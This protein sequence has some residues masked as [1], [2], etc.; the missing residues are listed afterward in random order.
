MRHLLNKILNKFGFTLYSKKK[1]N[2]YSNDQLKKM[3]NLDDYDISCIKGKL[4]GGLKDKL[5]QE[6]KIKWLDIGC[7]GHFENNFYYLDTF[8]EGM[9]REKDKYIRANI[10]HLSESEFEKIGKFDLIRMQHV[11]EHFTPEDGLKVLD[12]CAK[13]LNKDGYILIS[14]PDLRKYVHLYLT[15]RIKEN[16]DWALNR[17]D[18]NSP[19]SFYFSIFS[20]S[21][22]HEKHEWCYDAEGLIYQLNRTN[23]YK[24][25]AEISLSDNLANIPFT[26]NRPN[27][28]VCVLAQLK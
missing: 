17:I 1:I 2:Y 20:H 19:N 14:T 27:Q 22:L 15:D 12:N 8:P 23:K 24:N 9:I 13:L 11:F 5:I 21:M 26:H 3:Y 10:V 16:F 6:N 4:D 18:K 7:G 28:D 25:I